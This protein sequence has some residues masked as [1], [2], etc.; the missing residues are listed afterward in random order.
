MEPDLRLGLSPSLKKC[1]QPKLRQTIGQA[2]REH[3]RQ[4]AYIGFDASSALD[5]S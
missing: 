3:R 4:A 5:G 2:D 1:G